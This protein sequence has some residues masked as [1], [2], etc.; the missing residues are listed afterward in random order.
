MRINE[1]I[2]EL[3]EVKEEHGN[4]DITFHCLFNAFITTREF[5]RDKLNVATVAESEKYLEYTEDFR[6]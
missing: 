1:L 4:L 6:G 5:D 3:E 2:Q